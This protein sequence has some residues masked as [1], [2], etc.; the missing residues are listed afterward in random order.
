MV[1]QQAVCYMRIAHA[2]PD[3]ISYWWWQYERIEWDRRPSVGILGWHNLGPLAE[4]AEID[5]AGLDPF[6]YQGRD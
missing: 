4:L 2:Y 5:R 1:D 3:A 6:A